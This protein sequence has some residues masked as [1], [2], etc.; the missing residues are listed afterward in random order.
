MFSHTRANGPESKTTYMFSSS[1]PGGGKEGA[2]LPF[3]IASCYQ[4]KNQLRFASS[5]VM[6]KILWTVY[7]KYFSKYC[8]KNVFK[9]VFQKY[10]MVNVFRILWPKYIMYFLYFNNKIQNTLFTE[11]Y[12]IIQTSQTNESHISHVILFDQLFASCC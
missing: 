11:N 2:N 10:F 6:E 5:P 7:L 12:Y 4:K 3:P 8:L 1:S 9:M